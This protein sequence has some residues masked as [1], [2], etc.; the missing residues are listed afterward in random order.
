VYATPFPSPQF[1]KTFHASELFEE[2]GVFLFS[3]QQV[4][5]SFLQPKQYYNLVMHE[6]IKAYRFTYPNLN[7][8]TLHQEDWP[9]LEKI[10]GLSKDKIEGI[11]NLELEPTVVAGTLFF[12][13]PTAFQQFAPKLF[14]EWEI[15]FS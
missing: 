12:T 8:P 2:D 7:Y 6:Y 5:W 1:P 11:I 13:H 3:A 15:I 4:M 14:G 9:L 10:S